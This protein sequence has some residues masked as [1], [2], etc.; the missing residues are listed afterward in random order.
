MLSPSLG[1]DDP[2]CVDVVCCVVLSFA[3]EQARKRAQAERERQKDLEEI[4]EIERVTLHIEHNN[5]N[6]NNHHHHHHHHHHHCGLDW[7]PCRGADICTL[8]AVGSFSVGGG[9]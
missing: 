7:L 1:R 4:Q 8:A 2:A 5:N 3:E 9:Y 6:S